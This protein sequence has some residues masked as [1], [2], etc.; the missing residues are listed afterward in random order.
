MRYT[1]SEL[2]KEATSTRIARDTLDRTELA[3][4]LAIYSP[5]SNETTLRNIITGVNADDGVN[6]HNLFAVGRETVAKMKGQSI[7]SYSHK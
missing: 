2:H 1:T 3:A 7:F 4:T 6:V 5:F